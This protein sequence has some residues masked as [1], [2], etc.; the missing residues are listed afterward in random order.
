[1]PLSLAPSILTGATTFHISTFIITTFGI[2]TFSIEVK[3]HGTQRNG[4]Q[5]N[6]RALV[7]W[8]S[9]MLTVTYA[10]CSIY[11]PFAGCLYAVCRYAECRGAVL[12]HAE[13][14]SRFLV[15]FF[16]KLN[17]IKFYKICS[18]LESWASY[19]LTF[20]SKNLQEWRQSE[21]WKAGLFNRLNL[22]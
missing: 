13:R 22:G 18:W 8:V 5:H 11:I 4:T 12:L 6:G 14:L 2:M 3:K 7:A 1:M 19:S 17:R 10:K 21:N 20:S 15:Y 9:F 16:K